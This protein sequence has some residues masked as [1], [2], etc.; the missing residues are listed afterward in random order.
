LIPPV[1]SGPEIPDNDSGN[2]A[3]DY[4]SILASFAGVSAGLPILPLAAVFGLAGIALF[5]LLLY[6]KKN[7]RGKLLNEYMELQRRIDSIR[8]LRNNL[9]QSFRPGAPGAQNIRARILDAEEEL[10]YAIVRKR[11]LMKK[12]GMSMSD[13][14][15]NDEVIGL[16]TE[17]LVAG[18]DPAII[19]KALVDV[20]LPPLL[21]DKVRGAIK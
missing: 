8:V 19:K 17:K 21:V 9:T 10:L 16:I 12:L 14:E 2:K 7:G 1:S 3:D 18:E 5:A 6:K 15:G 20:G 11:E 4:S 13:I